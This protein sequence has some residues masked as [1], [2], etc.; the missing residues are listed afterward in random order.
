MSDARATVAA[1]KG[2]A[3][4]T[5]SLWRFL[6]TIDHAL[7]GGGFATAFCSLA[8][9]GYMISD[10]AR[11]PYFPGGEYLAIFAKPNHGFQVAAHPS[12]PVVR[13]TASNDSNGIDPTP[14]G[15]IASASRGE[16]PD[17]AAL[18]TQ[19]YRLVAANR[20]AAWVES[21]TGFRQ[22]KPGEALPGFGRI[23]TIERRNG[24]WTM[25]TDSGLALELQDDAAAGDT[26]GDTRFARQMI[27]GR[28]AQ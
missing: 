4:R 7:A 18:P 27:F 25:T 2:V 21:E 9:A 23:A 24:R 5:R 6:P 28:Q 8:F 26:K 14:T 1:A 11:Q 20:E 10:R 19:R 16:P 12:P 22:V 13:T 3:K 17:G 15:S